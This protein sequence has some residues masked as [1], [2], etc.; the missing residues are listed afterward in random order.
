MCV[1]NVIHRL[2]LDLAGPDTIPRVEVQQ[3]NAEDADE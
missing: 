3:E 2:T 1:E